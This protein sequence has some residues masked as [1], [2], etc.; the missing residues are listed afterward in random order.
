MSEMRI[1]P[2]R[3]IREGALSHPKKEV[4]KM[5]DN[6]KIDGEL[7]SRLF[8]AQSPTAGAG[9]MM[10]ASNGMLFMKIIPRVSALNAA[11]T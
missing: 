8:K 5:A 10:H 3:S 6:L 7:K 1:Y 9:Q 11:P 4:F 2:G